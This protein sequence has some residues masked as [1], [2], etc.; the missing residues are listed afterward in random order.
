[1]KGVTRLIAVIWICIG[2]LA[3]IF[4]ILSRSIL[5]NGFAVILL[6]G[7]IMLLLGSV[8]GWRILTFYCSVLVLID[9]YNILR[10]CMEWK[11]LGYLFIDNGFQLMFGL[12]YLTLFPLSLLALLLDRPSRWVSQSDN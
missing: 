1:M 12:I 5:I 8:W 11:R 9:A 10:K 3:L 4:G 6:Y 2:L 7:S